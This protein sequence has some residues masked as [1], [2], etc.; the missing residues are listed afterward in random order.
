MYIYIGLIIIIIIIIKIR[1]TVYNHRVNTV[2]QSGLCVCV[3]ASLFFLP[4]VL[5]FD[6]IIFDPFFMDYENSYTIH[7]MYKKFGWKVII[8]KWKSSY[9]KSQ[10]MELNVQLLTFVSILVAL[11][12]YKRMMAII[13]F[14]FFTQNFHLFIHSIILWII[15]HLFI[16]NL[17]W[18]SNRFSLLLLLVVQQCIIHHHSIII[19]QAKQTEKK[20]TEYS[21]YTMVYGL[22]VYS[23]LLWFFSYWQM[24]FFAKFPNQNT[25][26]NLILFTNDSVPEESST[27]ESK[28][29]FFFLTISPLLEK[30]FGKS[31]PKKNS[32]NNHKELL[33]KKTPIIIIIIIITRTCKNTFV[34]ETNKK[35]N[36]SIFS[37]IRKR[38]S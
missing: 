23:L 38:L 25:D 20:W 28:F 18:K 29:I 4:T 13:F 11:A 22:D 16:R 6:I 3:C 1:L 33:V 17:I 5:F 19:I 24:F 14:L 9:L 15:D 36:E 32:Q 27:L 30:F 7:T 8:F 12:Q 35:K 31:F 37:L 2:K 34:S 10:N 21:I 26:V